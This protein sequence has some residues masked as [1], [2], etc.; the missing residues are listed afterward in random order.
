MNNSIYLTLLLSVGIPIFAVTVLFLV[1][2]AVS[3]AQSQERAKLN[4]EGIVLDSG[5]QWITVRFRNYR[6]PGFYRGV[7]IIKS[8]AF[9]VLTRERLVFTLGYRRDYF[10]FP[11]SELG[12][13]SVSVADNGALCI[14]SDDP[15]GAKGSIDFR[16]KVSDS[17]T[18]VKTLCEAG[19]TL[20]K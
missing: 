18:W 20:A 7:G 4:G 2:R 16:V 8:R 10:R 19:A 3:L 1:L 9:V 11:R 13:F 14:H 17:T 12:R 5:K 15:P 6:A